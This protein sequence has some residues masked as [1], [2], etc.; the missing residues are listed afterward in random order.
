MVQDNADEAQT[1]WT[2]HNVVNV[3]AVKIN[4]VGHADHV[5]CP[6]CWL[7]LLDGVIGLRDENRTLLEIGT[8]TTGK[9]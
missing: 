6:K 4:A 2:Q 8:Q 1:V 9:E 5:P 3:F 7:D